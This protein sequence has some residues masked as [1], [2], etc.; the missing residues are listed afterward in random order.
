M[1]ITEQVAYWQ[2]LAETDLEVARRFLQRGENLHYCLFFGHMSL[3]KLIK[4]LVVLVKNEMPPK[5]HDLVRLAER[6]GLALDEELRVTLGI[7]NSFNLE[8]RYPDYKLSFYKRCTKEFA[9]EQLAKIEE[10]YTWLLK[11]FPEP[12]SETSKD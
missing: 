6:A 8:A 11:R 4:G 5:I 10:I 12:Y 7:F 1:T 2:T 3:E 9:T